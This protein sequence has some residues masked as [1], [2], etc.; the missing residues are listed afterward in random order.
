M[1]EH[2]ILVADSR[3]QSDD[4]GPFGQVV[5]LDRVYCNVERKNRLTVLFFI[6]CLAISIIQLKTFRLTPFS[7]KHINCAIIIWLIYF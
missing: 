5:T 4:R 3:G 7:D 2:L 6:A 1:S